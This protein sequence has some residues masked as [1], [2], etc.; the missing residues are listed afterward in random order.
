MITERVLAQVQETID[1]HDLLVPGGTVVVAVSGGPDSLCLLH[2]LCTLRRTCGVALHVAHLNHCLRG[3]ESA[4]DSTFVR[5]IAAE[6]GLPITRTS[7]NVRR[8]AA[9][10][11]G[12]VEEVARTVRYRFLASVAAKIGAE[13]IAVGHNADDQTETVLMHWLRGAGLAGLRGMRP[14]ARLSGLRLGTDEDVSPELWLIRPLLAVSRADIE[15]YCA[16]HGLQPRFDRSNLDTTYFRNRLRYELIPYLE[17]YNPN[18]RALIRRSAEV[19]A[20]DYDLLHAQVQRTWSDVLRGSGA[21][22]VAFDLPAWRV[23]PLALQRSLVRLAVQTLRSHLRDIGWEHVENAVRI[24]RERET[25]TQATLPDGLVLTVGYDELVI[26]EAGVMPAAAPPFPWLDVDSVTLRLPGISALGQS[27]WQLEA[28]YHDATP[29]ALVRA[30]C[31][32]DPNQAFLDADRAG[33][34]RLRRRAPGD[35]FCPLGMGGKRQRVREFMIN[36]KIPAQSRDRVPILV[37]DMG[38]VWIAGWRADERFK[39]QPDTRRILHLKLLH[40]P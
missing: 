39:V 29:D 14:K 17:T 26:A 9:E 23:L 27:G 13:R 3:K 19:L 6:W 25:G 33:D 7:V 40:S 35:W 2:V 37:S 28:A 10:Q 20:G 38:I 11:K 4:A 1:R 31:N 21:G 36:V 24:A 15:A 30:A 34:L 18:V 5:E 22:W 16:A 8:L 12:S 32:T